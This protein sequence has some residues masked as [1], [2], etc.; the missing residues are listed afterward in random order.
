MSRFFLAMVVVIS[1]SLVA[2]GFVSAASVPND[3]EMRQVQVRNVVLDSQSNQPVVVLK[4]KDNGKLLPLWIGP[5]E[6]QAII[7]QLRGITPPRPMTH[8]L[9]RNVIGGFKAK[10]VRIIITEL[11]GGTF[12]A[13]IEMQSDGRKFSI[14]S[15][16]SDAIALALR[17][18]APIFAKAQVL[19]DGVVNFQPMKLTHRSRLG[20]VLQ[21]M[22]PSLARYFGG[23]ISDGLLVS[24]VAP[25]KLAEKSGLRRGDVISLVEGKKI[26]SVESF[27][28]EF[29]KK[30]DGL[31]I[32][33]K[34]NPESQGIRMR[35]ITANNESVAIKK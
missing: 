25:G 28:K 5:A 22:T 17:V 31:N 33:V 14:D 7:I 34:R 27:E 16:P 18:K 20:V 19:R 29:I 32:F 13:H 6:A 30:S 24:Q 11:K 15:R 2:Q 26:S 8:D 1:F 3:S 4:E 12:Y 10:V 35:L 21:L 9:L 23:G